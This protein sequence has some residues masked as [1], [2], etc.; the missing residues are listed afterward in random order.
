MFCCISKKK[1][2][3]VHH[4]IPTADTT[5]ETSD[6]LL[7]QKLNQIRRISTEITIRERIKHTGCVPSKKEDT[8]YE[9]IPIYQDIN[10]KLTDTGRVKCTKF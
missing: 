5:C 8:Y 4:P 2:V 7:S 9:Y 6:P 3:K 10:G 1:K